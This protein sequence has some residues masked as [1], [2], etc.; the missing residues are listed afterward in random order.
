MGKIFLINKYCINTDIF[1]LYFLGG[2]MEFVLIIL[3]SRL[4]SP[5]IKTKPYVLVYSGLYD[6]IR[7]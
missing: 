5:E 7:F 6:S 4:I 1:S 2:E 3:V